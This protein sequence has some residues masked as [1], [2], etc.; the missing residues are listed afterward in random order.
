MNQHLPFQ[1]FVSQEWRILVVDN[2]PK[3]RKDHEFNLRYWGFYPILAEGEGE[4]LIKDAIEKASNFQC[5][6]ALVDQRLR[7]DSDKGDQSGLK[8]V[9]KLKPT[10][11]IVVTSFKNTLTIRQVRD[12][13]GAISL[14]EKSHG[15][16]KLQ[17]NI[18]TALHETHVL[19]SKIEAIARL[20]NPAQG[21]LLE[22]GNTFTVETG[23]QVGNLVL[24]R[25]IT[26]ALNNNTYELAFDIVLYAEDMEITPAQM[27]KYTVDQKMKTQFI[28]FSIMPLKAG[29]KFIRLDFFH[30]NQWLEKLIMNMK[31]VK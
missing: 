7:D 13:Y 20:K 21:S 3:F 6:L 16:E 17:Q 5:H 30:K 15:P 23:I 24:N 27:Q 8:L 25:D 31:V 29:E 9:S 14:V 26:K 19:N 18:E 28:T 12:E 1:R 2:D 10:P 11:S 22:V 4:Y